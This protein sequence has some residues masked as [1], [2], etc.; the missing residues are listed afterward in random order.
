MTR[1]GTGMFSSL[2]AATLALSWDW[3]ELLGVLLVGLLR[4]LALRV[5]GV[6]LDDLVVVPSQPKTASTRF[7]W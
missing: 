7:I 5:E 3:R 1:D 6:V 4:G 2:S